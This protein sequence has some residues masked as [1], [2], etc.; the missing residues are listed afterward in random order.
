VVA[1]VVLT[2]LLASCFSAALVLV[3]VP[4]QAQLLVCRADLCFSR[5]STHTQYLHNSDIASRGT[6]LLW[7]EIAFLY[8][9][10]AAF[11]CS[12]NHYLIGVKEVRLSLHVVRQV[13]KPP[14]SYCQQS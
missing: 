4:L 9:I 1:V 2:N 13:L 8:M 14:T 7:V 11:S 6:K 12:K 10:L 5:T 3:R